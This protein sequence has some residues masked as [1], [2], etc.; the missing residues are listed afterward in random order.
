MSP[1]LSAPVEAPPAPPERPGHLA[2]ASQTLQGYLLTA[3]L[4]LIVV[5]IAH[6]AGVSLYE[7]GRPGRGVFLRYDV[8]SWAAEACVALLAVSV[9]A[10]VVGSF[11]R[12]RLGW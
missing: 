11:L 1:V 7:P 5:V 2:V 3:I 9:T 10:L 4:G 12:S 6:V 8:W